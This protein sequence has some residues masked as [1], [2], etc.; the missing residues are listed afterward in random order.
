MFLISQKN[1]MKIIITG[2][3][4]LMLNVPGH[5]QNDSDKFQLS[6]NDN[7]IIDVKKMPVDID[8]NIDGKL[9]M[10]PLQN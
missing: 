10:V 1:S 9:I 6:F 3:L 8:I 5:A 7:Q 4:S 2:I